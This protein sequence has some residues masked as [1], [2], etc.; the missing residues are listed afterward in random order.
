[1]SMDHLIVLTHAEYVRLKR[2]LKEAGVDLCFNAQMS[3]PLRLKWHPQLFEK[4]EF[5]E[6]LAHRCPAEKSYPI[7]SV[8]C[9]K[10]ATWFQPDQFI[11]AFHGVSRRQEADLQRYLSEH[12]VQSSA[13]ASREMLEQTL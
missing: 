11:V 8:V 9:I 4:E 6:Y 1:M 5:L 13:H 7:A 10:K 2:E 12:H 3:Q